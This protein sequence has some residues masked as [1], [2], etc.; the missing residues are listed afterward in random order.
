MEN[1]RVGDLGWGF[2]EYIC[3]LWKTSTLITDDVSK[4]SEIL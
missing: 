3:A 2:E 1:K 4:I